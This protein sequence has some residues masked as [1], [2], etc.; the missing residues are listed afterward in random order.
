MK[1]SKCFTISLN[2][3]TGTSPYRCSLEWSLDFCVRWTILWSMN[4]SFDA[5]LI[6]QNHESNNAPV[7]YLTLLRSEVKSAHFCYEWIIVG[8]CTVG[9]VGLVYKCSLL[10]ICLLQTHCAHGQQTE[11]QM[12]YI[13]LCVFKHARLYV[14]LYKTGFSIG[15]TSDHPP[16][17][18]TNVI[19][20]DSH[21][22][23]RY[24]FKWILLL[25]DHHDIFCR[26]SQML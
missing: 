14:T 6:E 26:M 23:L 4:H 1:S 11:W 2:P 20:F 8:S 15:L 21:M 19:Y 17:S 16:T 10:I 22:M 13:E 3:V 18:D 7:R 12:I 24:T 5:A 9:F 25:I